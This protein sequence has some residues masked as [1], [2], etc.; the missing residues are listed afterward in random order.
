MGVLLVFYHHYIGTQVNHIE[1]VFTYATAG[2]SAVLFAGMV[3]IPSEK[4]VLLGAF[5]SIFIIVLAAGITFWGIRPYTILYA[6]VPERIDMLDAHLEET[7]PERNWE[8]RQSPAPSD[9]LYLLLVT[10]EDEPEIT[11][12]YHMSDDVVEG[13]REIRSTGRSW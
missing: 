3:L 4:K 11:H 8:I 10:F 6:E 5:V 9:S 13:E 1:R 2:I 7:Y 12:H